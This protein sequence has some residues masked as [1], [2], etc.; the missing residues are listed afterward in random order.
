MNSFGAVKMHFFVC[1]C[2]Q[3]RFYILLLEVPF[4][5]LVAEQLLRCR[6][7][8]SVVLVI[9]NDIFIASIFVSTVVYM[10]NEIELVATMSPH[11]TTAP[12]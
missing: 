5:F 12:K 3:F 11:S 2:V 9:N 4:A 6:R 10:S 7:R 1:N 8:F